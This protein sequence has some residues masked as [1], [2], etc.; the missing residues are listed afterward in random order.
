[1]PTYIKNTTFGKLVDIHTFLYGPRGSPLAQTY[2]ELDQKI[3]T[4]KDTK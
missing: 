3:E 4:W 1:M 2:V